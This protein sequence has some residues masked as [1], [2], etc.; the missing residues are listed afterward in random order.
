MYLN[1]E[2]EQL[3]SKL[4]EAGLE[5]VKFIKAYP[6]SIKPTRIKNVLAVISP[7]S[8]EAESDSI[9]NET[10]FG[11]YSL[12]IDV[13]SPID[14]GSP[15]MS[16]AMERILNTATDNMVTGIRVS[17]VTADERTECFRAKCTLTYCYSHCTE[18]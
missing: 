12:D 3:Y 2:A 4:C 10:L 9:G 1:D 15:M 7:S 6:Y 11:K 13:F 5:G 17:Q 8:I 14:A 16:D 18:D